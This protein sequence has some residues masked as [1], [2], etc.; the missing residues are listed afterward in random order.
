MDAVQVQGLFEQQWRSALALAYLLGVHDPEDV[1]AEGF[2]RL[3][4][5]RAAVASPDAATAYLRSV[6]VNLARDETRRIV[7]RRH[8]TK[9]IP[10]HEESAF[11]PPGP[12]S[13][14]M[15]ALKRLPARQREVVILRYWLDLSERDA[16]NAMAVSVGTVKTHASRALAALR[17]MLE[18]TL[19]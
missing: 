10:K 6:I 5:R 18:G 2:A 14:V 7:R 11:N 4:G 3:Y 12:D 15:A 13:D 1:A 19:R 8:S 16:A 9:R 17:P